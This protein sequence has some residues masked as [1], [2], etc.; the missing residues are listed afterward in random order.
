M[1]AKP[2]VNFLE[3]SVHFTSNFLPYAGQFI[4]FCQFSLCTRDLPSTFRVYAG[5]SINF[6][7][8]DGTFFKLSAQVQDFVNFRQLYMHPLVLPSTFCASAEPSVNFVSIFFI[9]GTFYKRFVQPRLFHHSF[10]QLSVYPW[11][12]P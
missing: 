12:I 6:L 11:D 3:L 10:Q 7:C 4:N 8:V 2:S 9:R 1:A 5:S